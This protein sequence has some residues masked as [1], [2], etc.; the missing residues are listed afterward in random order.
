MKKIFYLIMSIFVA[1]NADAQANTNEKIDS[2]MILFND[3]IHDFGVIKETD[4]KVTYIFEFRN[5]GDVP[6][7]IMNV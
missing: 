4:G 1:L 2:A 7:V 6:L 5:V 3:T